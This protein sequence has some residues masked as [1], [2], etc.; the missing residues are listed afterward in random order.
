MPRLG[1]KVIIDEEANNLLPLL[2]LNETQTPA[3]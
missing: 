2:N 3:K 1:K